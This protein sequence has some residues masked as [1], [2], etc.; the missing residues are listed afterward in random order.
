MLHTALDETTLVCGIGPGAR[1]DSASEQQ[2]SIE[3]GGNNWG[4]NRDKNVATL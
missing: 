2:T 3:L 4:E 1:F